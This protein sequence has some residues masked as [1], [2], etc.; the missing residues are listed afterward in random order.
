MLNITGDSVRK[1]AREAL[2]PTFIFI[3]L[4][5][6][7]L[8]YTSKL[9]HEY[10]TDIP[11]GIRIDGQKYR[12]AVTIRGRGS[13]IMA[14]RLSLKSRLGF[15]LD[16]LSSR[17]STETPGAL[18]I[19]KTSLQNAINSKINDLVI[20][21]VTEA[22]EFTPSPREATDGNSDAETAKERRQRERRERKEAKEAARAAEKEAVEI[23]E[24]EEPK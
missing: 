23:S 14:Q 5:S 12:I 3:L 6:A 20:V 21:Q 17:R 19:A 15:T 2:S 22:P 4:S 18:I 16:E 11:L 9:S 8:W 13:H 24:N 1:V 10:T 7:L